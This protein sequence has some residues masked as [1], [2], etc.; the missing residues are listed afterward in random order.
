MPYNEKQYDPAKQYFS[1]GSNNVT[2]Q[3]DSERLQAYDFYENLYRN[4][5]SEL[6]IE[7]RGEDQNPV[8]I[9]NGRKIVEATN[10]FLGVNMDYYVEPTISVSLVDGIDAYFKEMF[11][12]EK[13]IGKFNSNKRWGLVRGDAYFYVYA[14]PAKP[15]GRRISITEL[16]P[17]R[18]FE[19][20]DHPTDP[21]E[22][23]GVHIVDLVQDPRDT[24]PEKKVARRRTF[25]K[26]YNEMNVAVAISSELTFWEIGKWDDRT[27]AVR[28]KMEQVPYPEL[29]EP[30]FMLPPTIN[31]LPVYKWSNDPAPNSSWGTSQLSGMETPLYAI[32]QSLSDEDATLVFQGL[33]MFVTDAAPPQDAAGNTGPWNVGPQQ[34][35]EIS[36][37]QRFDR[38]SGVSSTAPFA[39]HMNYINDN[40]CE[41]GG[42]P[43]TAI[44]RVDVNSVQSGI[45]LKMELMPIIAA[46]N[47]KEYQI[48]N[49][50][51]AMFGQIA[52]QWLP[53]YETEFFG[54]SEAIVQEMQ[55][56]IVTVVFDDPM[57]KDRDAQIQEVIQL[58]TANLIL[59]SMAV[60]KLREL[61]WKYPEAD[62]SGAELSDWDIAGM[63]YQ[64]M[65]LTMQAMDPYS[66][67]GAGG[68]DTGG[69]DDGS[70][71]DDTQDG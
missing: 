30:A 18:V 15:F 33:G 46:N 52:S 53:A 45:A 12:R 49:M 26:L 16:D 37:G 42:V 9:P 64:Q 38:V 55:F 70:G 47:E 19:I 22:L 13:L 68:D 11:V 39:E 41:A 71:A 67:M 61:G 31:K 20:E 62:A 56:A 43:Q 51:D 48:V 63:L 3:N 25:R 24:K 1:G 32:N 14:D 34:V 5:A 10:R 44:G 28:E 65:S 29:E 6:E 40:M 17:R 58:D 36:N 35:I 69:Q 21:S 50:M 54:A 66:G 7:L 59:K 27:P 60:S 23:T 4:A 2:L 8:L 57:P